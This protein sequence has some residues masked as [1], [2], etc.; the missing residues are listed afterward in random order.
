MDLG[1]NGLDTKCRRKDWSGGLEW[2]TGWPEVC[3]EAEVKIT[4]VGLGVKLSIS[5]KSQ[6]RQMTKGEDGQMFTRVEEG[7]SGG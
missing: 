2:T 5:G 4:S 7:D 6:E 3:H 1:R